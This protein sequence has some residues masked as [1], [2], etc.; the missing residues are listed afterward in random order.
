MAVVDSSLSLKEA[1]SYYRK[2]L[3]PANDA[4]RAFLKDSPLIVY[5]ARA[6]NAHLPDWLD[7]ETKDWDMLTPDNAE[8][9]ATTLEKKLDKRY[10]GDF[11]AVEPAVHEGTFRIRNRVTGEVVADVTLKEKE[12]EFKRIKGINY[13]NLGYHEQHILET[14]DDPQASYRHWKDR[15][16][17]QRIKIFKAAKAKRAKR[18]PRTSGE[19]EWGFMYGLG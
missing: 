3:S 10:G 4:I 18:K 8:K 15:E 2:G 1:E 16:A 12:V 17:L 6:I 14:L 9:Q 7:R 13:A 5:G 19:D 11:F